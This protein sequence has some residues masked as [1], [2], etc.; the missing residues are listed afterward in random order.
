LRK[1]ALVI[2]VSSVAGTAVVGGILDGTVVEKV[3]AK[4]MD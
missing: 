3:M 4:I 1:K 2:G